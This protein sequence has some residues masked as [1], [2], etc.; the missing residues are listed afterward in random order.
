MKKIALC[1]LFALSS[2]AMAFTPTGTSFGL[3][4]PGAKYFDTGNAAV[5]HD[6][7]NNTGQ[8]PVDSTA[9]GAGELGYDA[10]Y[11]NTRGATASGLVDGDFVGVTGFT[12]DVGF[13]TDGV[14]GYQFQDPDGRMDLVFDQ[15]NTSGIPLVTVSLDYFLVEDNWESDDIVLIK[16][17]TDL[18]TTDLLNTTGLD[19][20]DLSIEGAW[21][22]LSVTIPGNWVQLTVSLDSN[23]AAEALYIDNVSIVPEPATMVLL[24]L[25]SLALAGR[26]RMAK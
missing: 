6:L 23:A 13:Y 21:T 26:R 15:V 2:T 14:Q 22:T 24:G 25:G 11:F 4:T 9:A 5:D 16:V 8:S 10:L 19:V 12:G 7:V 18:G 20:D 3:E 17:E 1:T